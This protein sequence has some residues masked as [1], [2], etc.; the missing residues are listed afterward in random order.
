[1][2]REEE[3]RRADNERMRKFFNARYDD[4]PAA[5]AGGNTGNDLGKAGRM[6]GRRDEDSQFFSGSSKGPGGN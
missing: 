2:K 3:F 4:I 5:F 6:G 1:M